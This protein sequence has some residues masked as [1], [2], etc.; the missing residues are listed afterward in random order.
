MVSK[1]HIVPVG[2][3]HLETTGSPLVRPVSNDIRKSMASFPVARPNPPVS[4]HHILLG[5]I[6][7]RSEQFDRPDLGFGNPRL[8]Q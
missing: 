5:E 6:I 2:A 3:S 1:T 7:P 8:S 4:F